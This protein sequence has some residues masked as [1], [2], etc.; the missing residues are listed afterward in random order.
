M[1]SGGGPNGHTSTQWPSVRLL[2][3]LELGCGSGH[4]SPLTSAHFPSCQFWELLG[5]PPL[6]FDLNHSDLV[7]GFC[8]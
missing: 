5:I 3:W 6:L 4:R 1:P 8:N 7:S 2:L